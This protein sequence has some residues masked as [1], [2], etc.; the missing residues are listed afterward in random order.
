[1]I[2]QDDPA[3]RRQQQFDRAQDSTVFPIRRALGVA[4]RTFDAWMLADE[5]ALAAVLGCKCPRQKDP[6]TLS[7]P[8]TKCQE[9]L[10]TGTTELSGLS[11]LY[12]AVAE[13]AE[14]T[15]IEERCRRGFAPFA[16]RVRAL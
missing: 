6:E 1:M 13:V 7:E 9:L 16:Q 10:E 15:Q 11:Y 4:V 12:A 8:K 5:K 2:D 14:L 3:E